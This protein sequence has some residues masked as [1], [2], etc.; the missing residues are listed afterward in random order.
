MNNLKSPEAFVVAAVVDVDASAAVA[1]SDAADRN[2]PD[3]PAA[4]DG[5]ASAELA[6]VAAEQLP[7]HG[8]HAADRVVVAA[9]V[10]D[11]GG[12][13]YGENVTN[14]T[15]VTNGNDSNRAAVELEGDLSRL[16]LACRCTAM[17]EE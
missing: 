1:L 17:K 3:S 12:G 7:H 11:V 5:G 16:G 4:G 6:A 10:V 8:I 2:E 15:N 9:V 14:V 13:G